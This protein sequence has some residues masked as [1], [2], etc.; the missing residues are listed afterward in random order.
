MRMMATMA[1][2]MTEGLPGGVGAG[3][4]GG[5]LGGGGGE[6][7]VDYEWLSGVTV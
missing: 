1:V 3:L 2:V 4:G 5:G 6:V 7:A